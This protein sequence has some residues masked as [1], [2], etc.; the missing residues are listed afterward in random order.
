[1]TLQLSEMNKEVKTKKQTSE[2]ECWHTP[3]N[4]QY[5]YDLFDSMK[6]SFSYY[7]TCMWNMLEW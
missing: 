6:Y 3:T 2:L 7:F 4:E 1:M 5:I